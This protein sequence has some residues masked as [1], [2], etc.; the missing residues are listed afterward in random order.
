MF[1]HMNVSGSGALS[2]E[3]FLSIYDTTTL[4]WELQYS[5]IP[6]YRDTWWLLQKFCEGAHHTT[7]WPHY[8]TIV[9][10]YMHVIHM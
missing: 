2:C 1:R 7:K 9:C 10:E 8:E 6:W 5:N 3:Q 4:Q